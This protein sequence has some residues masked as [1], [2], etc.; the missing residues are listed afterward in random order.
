MID[1]LIHD[2][3]AAK[4]NDDGMRKDGSPSASSKCIKMPSRI[5][6]APVCGHSFAMFQQ[7]AP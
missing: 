4:K 2:V 6:I 3:V 7:L 1:R 5:S